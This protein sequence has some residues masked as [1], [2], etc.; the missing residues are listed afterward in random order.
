MM[1]SLRAVVLFVLIVRI[2]RVDCFPVGAS[3]KQDGKSL[4]GFQDL[5]SS[6]VSID[7][8]SSLL[9]SVSSDTNAKAVDLNI[10][11]LQSQ[12]KYSAETEDTTDLSGTAADEAHSTAA[13]EAH[14]TAADEGSMWAHR[15][16]CS[17]G[18]VCKFPTE[19]EEEFV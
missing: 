5:S 13:D 14:S 17:R 11:E 9:Q 12:S 15:I 19:I 1:G 16:H 6:D 3:Q 8:A 4:Q 10:N 18:R 7:H 2:F